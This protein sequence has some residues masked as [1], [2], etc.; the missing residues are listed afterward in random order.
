VRKGNREFAPIVFTTV[1]TVVLIVALLGLGRWQLERMREKQALFAAF[2]AGGAATVQ[3]TDVP[4]DDGERYQHVAAYGR[5]DSARQ[6]LLDNMTHAGHAGYR[7]LTPF[8]TDA[9]RIVLVDRGWLATGPT[10]ATLPNVAIGEEYRRI[11][12]RL[13]FLPRAGIELETT[14]QNGTW[15]RVLSYPRMRDLSE[16]LQRPLDPRVIL[17][18][19]DEPAGF[20]REWRPSTVP[21]ERHLGYAVT[22]F[23]L[24]AALAVIYLVTNLRQDSG[25][26]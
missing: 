4:A 17:L 13:D 12:G 5:Y 10:R 16:A 9:G 25:N 20:V 11:A 26:S 6:F 19:A 24:A 14:A 3:L 15:P 1:I 22:W 21:P 18:D 2:A 23:A 7:V 8:L